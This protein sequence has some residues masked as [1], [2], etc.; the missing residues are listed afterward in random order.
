VDADD[1]IVAL[2]GAVAQV[3][4]LVKRRLSAGDRRSAPAR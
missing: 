1:L 3:A 2:H 4:E